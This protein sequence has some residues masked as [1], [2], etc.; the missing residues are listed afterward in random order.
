MNTNWISGKAFSC[1]CLGGNFLM[2]KPIFGMSLCALAHVDVCA[3]MHVLAMSRHSR[4][5]G[6][7]WAFCVISHHPQPFRFICSVR[8]CIGWSWD[9]GQGWEAQATK[10][11]FLSSC[12]LPCPKKGTYTHGYSAKMHLLYIQ[13]NCIT[14]LLTF[15]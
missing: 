10:G 14:F 1:V 12:P 3:F 6:F 8:E 5:R 2:E 4:K 15:T 13:R 11:H 9:C 7:L